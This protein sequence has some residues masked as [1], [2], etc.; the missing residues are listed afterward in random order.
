MLAG[1]AAGHDLKARAGDRAR[2]RRRGSTCSQPTR[3]ARRE[4]ERGVGRDVAVELDHD[5]ALVGERDR[6]RIGVHPLARDEHLDRAGERQHPARA[7]R[8]APDGEQVAEGQVRIVEVEHA[9]R[10]QRAQARAA[11]GRVDAAVGVLARVLE[12]DP[13]GDHERATGARTAPRGRGSGPG[14][15]RVCSRRRAAGRGHELRAGPDRDRDHALRCGHATGRVRPLL[16]AFRRTR[17]SAGQRS[18]TAQSQIRGR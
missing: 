5:L 12:P 14:P 7:Q 8:L 9:G 6:T 11:P 17:R 18:T 13:G 16:L 10:L 4:E 2:S 15:A 1:G 3:G